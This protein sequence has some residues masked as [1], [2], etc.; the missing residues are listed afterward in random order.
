MA[1]SS[2]RSRLTPSRRPRASGYTSGL[3]IVGDT[4]DRIVTEDDPVDPP[5]A[6]AWRRGLELDTLRADNGIVIRPPLVY[7][8][9]GG[10]V[11]TGLVRAAVAAGAARYLVSCILS[12]LPNSDHV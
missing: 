5:P 3:G 11:L 9:G 1:A 8:R 2:I 4:G 12:S 6:M 7:G 10:L